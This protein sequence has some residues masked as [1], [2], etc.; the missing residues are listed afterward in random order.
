MIESI[1][2]RCPAMQAQLRRLGSNAVFLCSQ[3]CLYC[4]NVILENWMRPLNGEEQKKINLKILFSY[5]N[6]DATKPTDFA[7]EL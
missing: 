7:A 4:R 2:Q 3:A 6:H 1:A 5:S